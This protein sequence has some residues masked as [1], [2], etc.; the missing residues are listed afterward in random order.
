[1]LTTCTA[2]YNEGPCNHCKEVLEQQE[3]AQQQTN[4]VA[5]RASELGVIIPAEMLTRMDR[6]H[7]SRISQEG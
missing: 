3:L 1:M 6:V 5:V 2:Y 4:E 7:L